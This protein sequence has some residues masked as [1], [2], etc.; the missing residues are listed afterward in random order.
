MTASAH[1]HGH[2]HGLVHDSI[3][4][5]RAGLRAVLASLAVLGVT[6]VAQTVVFLLSGSVALLADLIHNFGDALTAVRRESGRARGAG[7]T[8]RR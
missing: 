1:A 7:S 4:R 8:A 6:A 5:S 3:K 2:S